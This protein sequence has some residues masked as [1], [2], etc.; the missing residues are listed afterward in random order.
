MPCRMI[1]SARMGGEVC[2]LGNH[3]ITR[4]TSGRHECSG[5]PVYCTAPGNQMHSL[6][7]VKLDV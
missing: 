4:A 7:L 5:L 6:N 3:L 2:N 1:T